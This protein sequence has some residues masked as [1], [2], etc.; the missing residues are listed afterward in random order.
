MAE[1]SVVLTDRAKSDYATILA[2]SIPAVLDSGADR[3][4]K[5]QVF[6]VNGHISDLASLID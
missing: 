6:C 3:G 2:A 1:L 5:C 4:G